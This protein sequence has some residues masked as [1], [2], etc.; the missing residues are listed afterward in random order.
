M[1]TKTKSS[2]TIGRQK[3]MTFLAMPLADTIGLVHCSYACLFVYIHGISSPLHHLFN[4]VNLQ[5]Q[6]ALQNGTF[7][8]NISVPA[9]RPFK[10]GRPDN[11]RGQTP[12]WPGGSSALRETTSITGPKMHK[13]H[14][15]NEQK[16][17][18][19]GYIGY[20]GDYTT[21]LCGAYDQPYK[22]W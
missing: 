2:G 9:S 19:L 22:T 18:C 8:A 17:G 7:S 4:L 10:N 1:S 6:A 16:A 5:P 13:C 12:L 14:L 20:I 11:S 3:T 15:S 21:Q